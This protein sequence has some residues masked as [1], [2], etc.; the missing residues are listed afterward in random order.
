MLRALRHPSTRRLAIGDQ[1]ER[2]VHVRRTGKAAAGPACWPTMAHWSASPSGDLELSELEV[3]AEARTR[4]EAVRMPVRVRSGLYLLST[5][6]C[7]RR[8]PR[9]HRGDP[10][11]AAHGEGGAD[12]R[13]PAQPVSWPQPCGSRRPPGQGRQASAGSQGSSAVVTA[14]PPTPAGCSGCRYVRSGQAI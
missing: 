7:R 1:P 13:S 5:S 2:T 10:L 8:E 3:R 11:V 6:R 12:H 14:R 4:T 9:R